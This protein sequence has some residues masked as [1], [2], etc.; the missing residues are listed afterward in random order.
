MGQ[1]IGP[2]NELLL[3]SIGFKKVI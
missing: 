2:P 1:F 3:F